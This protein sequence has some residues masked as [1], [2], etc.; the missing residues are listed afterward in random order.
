MIVVISSCGGSQQPA[1]ENASS[2]KD[3]VSSHNQAPST[4]EQRELPGGNQIPAGSINSGTTKASSNKPVFEYAG[5]VKE[6][7]FFSPTSEELVAITANE[8]DDTQRIQIENFEMNSNKFIE[9]TPFEGYNYRFYEMSEIV[10]P[11][12]DGKLFRLVRNAPDLLCGVILY[13]GVK[14]PKVL[15]GKLKSADYQREAKVYFK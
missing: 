5:K 7:L 8:N 3:T 11:L 12:P 14:E 2:P 6:V 13:D 1:T 10:L 4:A 15:S 9:S